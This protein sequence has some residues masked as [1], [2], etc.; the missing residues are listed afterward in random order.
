MRFWGRFKQDDDD[1]PTIHI[2]A[3]TDEVGPYHDIELH[4]STGGRYCAGTRQGEDDALQIAAR[5]L[6]ESYPVQKRLRKGK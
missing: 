4:T 2:E 6:C 1:L 3:G 5:I